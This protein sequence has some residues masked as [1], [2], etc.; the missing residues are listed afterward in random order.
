MDLELFGAS[1]RPVAQVQRPLLLQLPLEDF[2]AACLHMRA[3]SLRSQELPNDVHGF[4]EAPLALDFLFAL[5]V[6][7]IWSG[8]GPLFPTSRTQRSGSRTLFPLD[9]CFPNGPSSLAQ[10]ALHQVDATSTSIRSS[11]SDC[12]AVCFS[13]CLTCRNRHHIACK[14]SHLCMMMCV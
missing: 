5:R 3:E 11:A 6:S 1:S 12:T 7:R 2:D 4:Y 9:M 14:G 10:I 8:T 13:C